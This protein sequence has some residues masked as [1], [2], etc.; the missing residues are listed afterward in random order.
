MNVKRIVCA[1]L[2]L[3]LLPA[4]ALAG[5]SKDYV[6]D[7]NILAEL[8]NVQELG[9]TAAYNSD[10]MAL[11]TFN[12]GMVGFSVHAGELDGV[13]VTGT[14]ENFLIYSVIAFMVLESSAKNIVD[15]SGILFSTY[16]MCRQD[17]G[18]ERTAV[19]DGGIIF[20]IKSYGEDGQYMMV[21]QR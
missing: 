17:N 5:F 9:K 6:E 8:F 13:T 16:L 11:Y 19:A 18:K 1:V 21:A 4:C 20:M 15:H 14:G 2:V 10:G 12:G 7:F 3:C